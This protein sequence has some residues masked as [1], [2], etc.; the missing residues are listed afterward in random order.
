[1]GT[2]GVVCP[3]VSQVL[4]SGVCHTVRETGAVAGRK[5]ERHWNDS[6]IRGGTWRGTR[7][8]TSSSEGADVT[9]PRMLCDALR[10]M[11]RAMLE[12]AHSIFKLSLFFSFLLVLY[13]TE[14]AMLW[15]P[16]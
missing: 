7:R 14:L 8:G 2:L 5:P 15:N 6:G 16:S 4:S 1:M 3:S 10:S 11:R 13:T 9:G 12:H